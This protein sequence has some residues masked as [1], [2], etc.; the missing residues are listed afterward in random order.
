FYTLITWLPD[1]LQSNGYSSSSAGWM[2]FLMQFSL[3][4]FTFIMPVVAE[5]M[6]NQVGLSIGTA[7]LFIVGFLGLLQGSAMLALWAI[8]L[9]IAGGSAFSLSM[10]FFTLRTRDGQEAAELSGMAQSFGYLLAAVG[11]V[12][13]GA[14]HDITGGWVMP[15]TLLIII[16]VIVLIA[17]IASGKEGVIT[18]HPIHNKPTQAEAN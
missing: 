3:I 4:P 18:D 12:L 15:L 9:G 14:L 8:L 7:V 1:I 5:K 11:P 16:S 17:G 6:K 13:V 10:M 2:V